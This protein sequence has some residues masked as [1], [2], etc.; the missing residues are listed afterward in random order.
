[1]LRDDFCYR[2]QKLGVI[3]Q[4]A[5][6]VAHDFNNSFQNILASMELVRKLVDAGRGSEAQRFVPSAMAS[7]HR[8]AALAQRW[9]DFSRSRPPSRRRADVN[10]LISEIGELLRGA[11]PSSMNVE[12]DLFPDSCDTFG[13]ENQIETA[14]LD[15]ILD[16]RDAMPDGGNIVIRTRNA[17]IA[18][19]GENPA[20]IRPGQYICISVIDPR[21][22]LDEDALQRV[23]DDKAAIQANR[24]GLDL[25]RRFARENG[26]DATIR[27]TVGAGTTVT[28]FLPRYM[29]TTA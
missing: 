18:A 27:S 26:G 4:L 16:A 6:G 11:L 13:D 21:A 17:D 7:A 29:E 20:G 3:E 28:L 25:V 8:A 2:L 12:L 19:A 15:L 22:G 5:G 10:R 1:L 23:V 24:C 14:V 9:L